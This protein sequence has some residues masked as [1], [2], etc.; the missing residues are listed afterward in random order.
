MKIY[1]EQPTQVVFTDDCG[2]TWNYGIAYQDEIICM[3]CG[4]LVS[5]EELIEFA[6]ED[7]YEGDIIIEEPEWVDITEDWVG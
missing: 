6:Q 5:I 4:C 2:E 1:Y 7:N 3:C